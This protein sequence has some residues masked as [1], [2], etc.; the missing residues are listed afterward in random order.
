M[1]E[2][3]VYY[4]DAIQRISL[5]LL[6]ALVAYMWVAKDYFR[7]Y[8]MEHRQI[9][10]NDPVTI[11]IVVFYD[12]LYD[13]NSDTT[14]L[15]AFIEMLYAIIR[16]VFHQLMKPVYEVGKMYIRMFAVF[17]EILNTIRKQIM[18]LRQVMTKIFRDIYNR[19]EVGMASINF[20]FF[21]LRDTMKRIYASTKMMTYVA[22]HSVNFLDAMMSSPIGNFGRKIGDNGIAVSV[23]A[24][25]AGLG[26]RLW[27]GANAFPACFDQFARV[28]VEMQHIPHIQQ[29]VSMNIVRLGHRL[30][31]MRDNTRHKVNAIINF[32]PEVVNYTYSQMR[33]VPPMYRM[34]N[35]AGTVVSGSHGVHLSA[36]ELRRVMHDDRAEL[37]TEYVSPY[38]IVSFITDTGIVPTASSVTYRDYLD[39]HSVDYYARIRREVDI[40][41]NGTATVASSIMSND[42]YLRCAD[43]YSGFCI[44]G[45]SGVNSA[46]ARDTTEWRLTTPNTDIMGDVTIAFGQLDMYEIDGV[47]GILLSGNTWIYMVTLE[48]SA[49]A[50]PTFRWTLVSR[51]PNARYVGKNADTAMNLITRNNIIEWANENRTLKIRDFIEISDRSFLE[52]QCDSLEEFGFID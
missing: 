51:H 6:V 26:G 27:Q 42:E 46:G 29:V 16:E 48:E 49:G 11:P 32:R 52:Q 3:F 9:L 2:V 15:G 38:G 37:L 19:L 39:T 35:L 21:K 20:L 10:Q 43:L 30:V 17:R 18:M 34:Y 4:S 25:P 40:A 33:N 44:I 12:K 13:S 28:Y 36:N 22:Q 8:V 50:V 7:S 41:L 23:F 45:T 14:F 5:Y 47:S 24:A 31:D 1:L